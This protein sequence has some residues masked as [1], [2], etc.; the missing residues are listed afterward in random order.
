M[1]GEFF[2]GCDVRDF[3]LVERGIFPRVGKV[4]IPPS[5]RGKKGD[6]SLRCE[7]DSPGLRQTACDCFPGVGNVG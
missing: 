3:F 4:K 7:E 5:P 1:R 2:L 6:F